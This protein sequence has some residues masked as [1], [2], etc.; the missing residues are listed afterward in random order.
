MVHKVQYFQKTFCSESSRSAPFSPALS[1]CFD[2][3]LCKVDSVRAARTA[4]HAYLCRQDRY[5][6]DGPEHPRRKGE[7]SAH[8]L[9][10]D[11]AT[12]AISAL[13]SKRTTTRPA[14]SESLTQ[15]LV[16][17]AS[18]PRETAM[19]GAIDALLHA[20]VPAIEI[21]DFYIPES[22]RRLGQFWLED[23]ASFSEVTVGCARLQ[24]GMRTLFPITVHPVDPGAGSVLVAVVEGETH[25]LGA[26]VL[27]EQLRRRGIAVRLII[28]EPAPRLLR[29]VAEGQFDAIF[30]SVAIEEKLA[31]LAAI[32][33]KLRQLANSTAPI[34]VGGAITRLGKEVQEK[35][36]ADHVVDDAT[37]AL[38]LCGLT[39][40]RH[41]SARDWNIRQGMRGVR[42]PEADR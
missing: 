31:D 12:H 2:I 30:L 7:S 1:I 40:S 13:A 5:M 41:D 35:T 29:F 15:R 19:S 37:E 21:L 28:G 20:G 36:G 34:L 18:A 17:A 8:P 24:R 9:V 42:T 23:C 25:T 27:A 3:S 14:L 4:A 16:E 39:T 10:A 6:T 32:V 26:M 22:A 33:E 38:R 11:L